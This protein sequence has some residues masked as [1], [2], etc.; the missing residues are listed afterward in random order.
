MHYVSS[1]PFLVEEEAV[2]FLFCMAEVIEEHYIYVRSNVE[3]KDPDL[4][5]TV[6]EEPSNA[7]FAGN[8]KPLC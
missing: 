1:F 2:I 5:L 6:V 3:A 8:W 7:I 4:Y